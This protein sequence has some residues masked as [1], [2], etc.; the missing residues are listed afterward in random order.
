MTRLP[1]LAA[2][3]LLACDPGRQWTVHDQDVV[4]VDVLRRDTGL[5]EDDR[6][7]R[8]PLGPPDCFMGLRGEPYS[9]MHPAYGPRCDTAIGTP[10]V[11]RYAVWSDGS[12]DVFGLSFS[13]VE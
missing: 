4:L 13:E 2:F 7:P 5:P 11:V 3:V 9:F 1:F 8:E 12:M 10:G 6:K